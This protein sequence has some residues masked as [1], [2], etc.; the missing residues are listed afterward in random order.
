MH[1][2]SMRGKKKTIK[3]SINNIMKNKSTIL[4]MA[5]AM[6]T[7]FVGCKKNEIDIESELKELSEETF[8]SLEYCSYVGVKGYNMDV[9]Q[10]HFN[11]ADN[12]VE[13]TS[14]SCGDGVPA[15][16]ASKTYSFEWD[17]FTES[18]LGRKARLVSA[19]EEL[20]VIY[21]NN[22][23]ALSETV[24]LTEM[25]ALADIASSI[26]SNISN[27]DWAAYDPIYVMQDR[28][29]MDTTWYETHREGKKIIVDTITGRYK[30]EKQIP[31]G[32]ASQKISYLRFY[33]DAAS[34]RKTLAWSEGEQVNVVTSDTAILPQVQN[35]AK[36]DTIITFNILEQPASRI[37]ADSADHWGLG[38]VKDGSF[39]VIFKLAGGSEDET[40]QMSA[41]TD[42]TFTLDNA[43][44]HNLKK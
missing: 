36:N 6:M 38:M 20:N 16:F 31:V 2:A 24:R 42:S 33:D 43:I 32:V 12:T 15:A 11:H 40:L 4:I 35:P 30:H 37:F 22:V 25:D 39:D 5:L 29:T 7:A 9:I 17:G 21:L 1:R 28:W 18:M 8:L 10:F 14:F 3:Q 26:S 23:F 34:H 19:D 13:K 41:Y 27:S 44:Y